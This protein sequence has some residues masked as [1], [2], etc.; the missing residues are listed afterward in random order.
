MKK[1]I[2]LLLTA[3][4]TLL[5]CAE[6]GS[7]YNFDNPWDDRGTNYNGGSRTITFDPNGGGTML[8]TGKT[9]RDKKLDSLPTL[10][11][12]GCTFDGWYTAST[13]GTAVTTST[14]FSANATIYARW[15]WIGKGNNISNYKT[16][17]V[18]TQKWMAENL[19]YYVE[20]SK[21]YDNDPSN[22]AKYG[23]LY[24]WATAMGG[25]PSSS[26]NP[27]GVQ[28]VCPAGWHLPS[29]AE[30]TALTDTVGGWSTAGMK[31]KATS[32]WY[33]NGNGTDQYGFSAL[34]SGCGDGV[35]GNFYNAGN[36]GYWL[37]TSE[38]SISD[39]ALLLIM[40]YKDEK[41]YMDILGDNTFLFS[42][43]CVEDGNTVTFDA[44]GGTI[45]PTSG[46]TGAD[47]R[48][49]SLP[50][51]EKT[52]YTFN[53]WYTS[54]MGDETVTTNTIFSSDATV[55]ARWTII[56]GCTFFTDN[57]D[58]KTYKKIVIGNQTWMGE[59]LN[60][61][62][63]NV[64][65][66]VCYDNSADNCEKYGRLYNWATAMDID[67]S[68]NSINWNGSDVNHT[69]V[70]PVGWH[71]P[72][73]VEWM[74]LE[75]YVGGS[76]TA[77]TKLKSTTGWDSGDN[78]TDDYGF[79]AL[80]GGYGTSAGGFDGAG[81]WRG[82]WWSGSVG[83][84]DANNNAWSLALEVSYNDY[85]QDKAYLFSV[86]CVEN[87]G[88]QEVPPPVITT[89]TD[90]RDGKTYKQVTIGTQTWMG[91]N[92]NYAVE[93][94]KCYGEGAS[95]WVYNEATD[96]WD[97]RTLSASEVQANCAQYGRLYNWSTA[98]GGASSSSLSPSGV[99]G[100]C[101]VGWHLPSDAEWTT[102]VN[103]AGTS[104]MAGTK[105]KSTSGWTSGGNGID[106]YGFSAL[107]AGGGGGSFYESA[108]LYGIW[109]S[110]TEDDAS[111][112]WYRGMFFYDEGVYKNGTTNYD[113][114]NLHSVRCVAN[115]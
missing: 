77:V 37:S 23:R 104:Y 38:S 71:L 27:S 1:L 108:G 47:G 72:S 3:L 103:Y 91:E 24:D 66:D 67:A 64:T 45:S 113:E 92:L 107:P 54:A 98:M 22:C 4:M 2:I 40:G 68:Y 111:R 34:P 46:T 39:Y 35:N 6:N 58:G 53:G 62:V 20:G 93:G 114:S 59:N 85:I 115:Q 26:L 56:S 32:D 30:W 109:W 28:G 16:V 83:E 21:C 42:V 88:I 13:G 70:C 101:P 9:N 44:S 99:Q 8:S 69:G 52:C 94:S 36:D 106:Q 112:V 87:A 12:D 79:S 90:S 74:V 7:D 55:Y 31:L 86:R 95:T 50:T 78:G 61:D 63:P 17:V 18:G 11:R 19:D 33:N 97:L 57:R 29:V 81:Y 96:N 65:S 43:R 110:A 84:Y 100:A 75:E 25:M 76:S 80:P 102:L 89:F 10:T 60:Y 5:S 105:L 51:P 14:V 41:V 15:N 49:A 73:H 82:I 48:L